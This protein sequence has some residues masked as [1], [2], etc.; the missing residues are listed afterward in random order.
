MPGAVKEVTG[1]EAISRILE[2]VAT[3][4]HDAGMLPG[5]A[6]AELFARDVVEKQVRIHEER[7][8]REA[9][10]GLRASDEAVEVPGPESPSRL[11]RG[12]IP[13][14]TQ[15]IRN[16][17]DGPI[18]EMTPQARRHMLGPQLPLIDQLM[19]ARLRM[20]RQFPEWEA[21]IQTAWIAGEQTAMMS[22]SELERTD[23]YRR[24]MKQA[25]A[26]INVLD[27]S[28]A[29]FGD[30]RQPKANGRTKIIMVPLT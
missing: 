9:L 30:W 14:D 12:D 1:R 19:L 18:N 16:T 22:G 23:A 4:Q 24:H 17:L 6:D 15:V 13:G 25:E 26:V 21:R 11:D 20:L 27:D 5:G 2:G 10:A 8:A 7:E 3:T 29:I 28:I